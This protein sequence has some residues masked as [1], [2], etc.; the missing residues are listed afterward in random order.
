MYNM[1]NNAM[2]DEDNEYEEIPESA[3]NMPRNAN[4]NTN[5]NNNSNAQRNNNPYAAMTTDPR[6]QQ[7]DARYFK[8]DFDDDGVSQ[9]S[10]GM[11]PSMMSHMQQQS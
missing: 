7:S 6:Y 1:N 9:N 5:T 10:F 4:N 11:P 2:N 8:A 3:I